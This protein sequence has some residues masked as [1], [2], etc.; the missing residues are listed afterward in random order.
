MTGTQTGATRHDDQ[1]ESRCALNTHMFFLLL[2]SV[3]GGGTERGRPSTSGP[4]S[5]QRRLCWQR[6]MRARSR[7]WWGARPMLVQMMLSLALF[8]WK[9]LQ[10]W[11]KSLCEKKENEKGIILFYL[12]SP[13]CHL[14]ILSW[15][16]S[17]K[18]QFVLRFFS[19]LWVP[20]PTAGSVHHPWLSASPSQHAQGRPLHR[21]YGRFQNISCR[22][23][24][25]NRS[26]LLLPWSE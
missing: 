23:H 25:W 11:Q 1:P 8:Y 20:V 15:R 12:W 18:G 7:P 5:W 17:G 9:E 26:G 22:T 19:C 16:N 21:G 14:V 13:V 24:G 4:S 3:G 2:A 6:C 10:H